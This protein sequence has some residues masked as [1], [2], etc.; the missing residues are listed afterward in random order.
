MLTLLQALYTGFYRTAGLQRVLPSAVWSTWRAAP[1]T[2]AAWYGNNNCGMRWRCLDIAYYHVTQRMTLPAQV[3]V[4]Q[5]AT[6]ERASIN[7]LSNRLVTGI[8]CFGL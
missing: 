1:S 2:L 6:A 8:R 4:A 3:E 7:Q 5:S